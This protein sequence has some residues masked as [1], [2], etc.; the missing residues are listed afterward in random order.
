MAH[1]AAGRRY[2]DRTL[3]M[4]KRVMEVTKTAWPECV[5]QRMT[6]R[7]CKDFI[8]TTIL[9][10]FTGEDQFIRTRIVGERNDGDEWYNAIVIQMDDNDLVFG[11]DYDGMVHYDFE[12]AGSG[13]EASVLAQTEIP[14]IVAT[15]T[16]TGAQEGMTVTTD[17]QPTPT[18]DTTAGGSGTGPTAPAGGAAGGSATSPTEPVGVD[19]GEAPGAVGGAVTEAPQAPVPESPTDPAVTEAPI[20]TTDVVPTTEVPIDVS[21]TGA[22]S[23]V[24]DPLDFGGAS[25]TGGV[26]GGTLTDPTPGVGDS[27]LFTD[28][29]GGVDYTGAPLVLEDEPVLAVGGTVDE[30]LLCLQ[31]DL[32]VECNPINGGVVLDGSA[33]NTAEG[34]AMLEEVLSTPS[35]IADA[36]VRIIPAFNCTGLTG[37]ACCLS[38][39]HQV[40]DADESGRAIQC[41]LEY[42]EGTAKKEYYNVHTSRKIQIY[43]NG[44]GYTKW[45]PKLI[46]N[47]DGRQGGKDWKGVG[48]APTTPAAGS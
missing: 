15:E 16:Q 27:S 5:A 19:W 11:R 37:F 38:I 21:T 22:T 6:A 34:D 1:P 30:A 7:Q 45:D 43:A 48:L 39:K 3:K 40:R 12:W 46:G 32:T 17:Y 9:T 2:K 8:D 25:P 47:W 23:P 10:E 20:T 36:G 14:P 42:S 26:A 28:T 31:G 13:V 44:N 4:E 33:T 24:I 29:L 41:F 18:D 35:G